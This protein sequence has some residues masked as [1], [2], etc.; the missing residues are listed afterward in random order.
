MTE[1][2]W[3]GTTMRLLAGDITQVSVDVVVNAA[4]S[5]LAGGSGVDGA[6]HA[7]AGPSVMAELRERSAGCPTGSAVLTGGGDLPARF[8]VHAV[9]PIWRGGDAGEA[10]LLA[11]AYASALD[12]V[13]EAGGR[14][15]A[16][17]ALSCG[18]YGYPLQEAAMVALSSV[19]TWLT[20]HPGSAVGDVVFV[21]RGDAV[22]A[23]FQGAVQ[24]LIQVATNEGDRERPTD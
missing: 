15:V 13:Q 23:A 22:M 8:I 3:K 10:T 7:A 4:N 18:V 19:R 14:T 12:L 24:D 2:V 5:A 1:V 21:L 17:P 20:T 11:S 6:I 9:G 16:F